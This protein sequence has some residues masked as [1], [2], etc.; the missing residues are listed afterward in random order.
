M[1]FAKQMRESADFYSCLLRE[2][3]ATILV[4]IKGERMKIRWIPVISLMALLALLLPVGA[5]ADVRDN[6]N[7]FTKQAVDDADHDMKRIEKEHGK[8]LVIETFA[9]I[10]DD[11]KAGQQADPDGF[12]KKWMA[13]RA[14]ELKVNGVYVL[15]CMD[16]KHI[17]VGAGKNT[18]KN[19]D[20][21]EENIDTLRRQMQA[22]L[23]NKEYDKALNGA[24]DMVEKSFAAN[25]QSTPN[26]NST[27]NRDSEYSP[28]RYQPTLPIAPVSG[29]GHAGMLSGF[30]PLI[31]L[32]VGV[33]IIISLIRSIFRGGSTGSNFGGG[34]SGGNYGGNYPPP[35]QGGGY[36]GGGYGGGFGGGPMGGGGSGFGRGFLGGLLGGAVGGYAADKFDHRNDPSNSGFSGDG[37]SGGGGSS[38]GSFGD[39]GSSSSFDSGPSDSGQGFG[40]SSSGGDFG[41]SGGGGSSGGDF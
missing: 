6:A 32:A 39:S 25:I 1:G 28:G 38:G 24:V 22:D 27:V 5:R 2:C 36:G 23:H 13:T 34:Y 33:V 17:E 11:Q 41:S 20:F 16:P 15:I 7:I 19:G 26:H 29:S 12:F 3:S 14:K 21:T 37:G 8:Q 31:C 9:S 40:D 10:P 18:L 35:N 4:L 30:G